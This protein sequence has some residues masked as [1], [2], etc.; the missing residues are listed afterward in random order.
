MKHTK[1]KLKLFT[2]KTFIRLAETTLI[3]HTG[4]EG[5][6]EARVELLDTKKMYTH[7]RCSSRR[8]SRKY[9]VDSSS[10]QHY[11]GAVAL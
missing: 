3:V 11:V 1:H 9:R 8:D 7:V 6:N 5:M 2:H 4:S 10:V